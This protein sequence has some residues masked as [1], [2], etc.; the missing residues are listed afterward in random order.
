MVLQ[1]TSI[2]GCDSKMRTTAVWPS[3]EAKIKGV[4]LNMGI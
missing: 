2:P 1:L 4:S 3:R